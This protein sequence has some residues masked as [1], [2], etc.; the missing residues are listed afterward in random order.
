MLADLARRLV[1][2]RRS[3]EWRHQGRAEISAS[4]SS[5][6]SCGAQACATACA[7][8]LEAV[9]SRSPISRKAA[10][11]IISA[12]ASPATAS[13]SAGSC[14]ISRRCSTTMRSCIELM[15]EVLARDEVAA[16]RA[17]HRA[18]PS[19]GCC[20]RWWCEG[21]GFAASLDADSE[22]EEGKFYV[23]SSREI[24]EVLGA[25][26]AHSVRRD[27]RR[28]GGR[29]F[30]RPQYSQ[31]TQQLSSFAT[32]TTERVSPDAVRSCSRG[33]ARRVRPGFD[34]KVLADWNGLMIAALANAADAFDKPEWLAGG[35]ARLRLH[36]YRDDLQRATA[37][38]PIA[39][40]RRRRRRPPTTTPT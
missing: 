10:S 28:D 37:P 21:G 25:D 31:P 20:A 7:N 38:L 22:G 4:R 5:S 3:G 29:Q 39:P 33:A 6:T 32:Q 8:P 26:D 19:T 30:R 11:T 24:E 36:Q 9:T 40:A 18:R 35:R 14:R 23:W 12:A 15:T 2:A 16:L 27:L 1:Q 17:A 34:D 13:M